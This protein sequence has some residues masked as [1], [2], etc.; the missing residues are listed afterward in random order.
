MRSLL[1]TVLLGSMAA[2]LPA[3]ALPA[4][5][6]LDVSVKGFVDTYHLFTRAQHGRQ[7]Q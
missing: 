6:G 7:S 1:K 2:L 4:Q 5:D 3:I